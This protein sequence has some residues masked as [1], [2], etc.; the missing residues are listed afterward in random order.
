MVS[1]LPT[2]WATSP[3]T[4]GPKLSAVPE[5]RPRRIGIIGAGPAGLAAAHALRRSGQREVIVLEREARV[6]G[7]CCSFFH[8]GRTY[9]L[10][11]AAMTPRYHHVRAL[12]EEMG[13][14]A[15]PE[16]S[17][18]FLELGTGTR[19]F[20][21]RDAVRRGWL[22]LGLEC[23]KLSAVFARQRRLLEPG[24]AGAD[25][26]LGLPFTTW[27][28]CHGLKKAGELMRPW[29]TAF[30]YGYLE[31]MPAAYVLKY[32]M[33]IGGFPLSELVETGYQGLWERVA[34]GLDVRTSVQIHG[35]RREPS[36]VCLD[37][38]A[39]AFE[40]DDV[41]VACSPD[42]ALGF[43]DADDEERQ[44]FNQIKYVDYRVLVASV[45]GLP[46]HRYTFC[47]DHLS[48]ST[49]GEPMFWHRRFAD[50][51]VVTFYCIGEPARGGDTEQAVAST[52]RRLGGSLE[53]TLEQRNWRYFPHVD[54]HA[55]CGGFHN[56]FANLQGRRGAYYVGEFLNFATVETSV[57]HAYDL[58]KH[59]LAN[60]MSR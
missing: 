58:V 6:G 59:R 55:F 29:F 11:A 20:V 50:T 24:Y 25:L 53:R 39:G 21:S 49:R 9:E 47:T 56:R 4:A 28:A 7:K 18:S 1:P 48:P 45:R 27:A 36:R 30:G 13:L 40:F 41:V 16:P 38:S 46:S 10:G 19:S 2:T 23:V 52:V 15:T 33:S 8:E 57:A 54:S 51:N 44:L 14:R 12:I 37:T 43:L 3:D 17:A 60:E 26:E 34:R 31:E 32:F 42:A 22:G 35:L 5:R